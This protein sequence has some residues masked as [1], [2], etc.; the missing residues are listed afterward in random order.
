MTVLEKDYHL[1]MQI[2]WLNLQE[3]MEI[4]RFIIWMPT[5]WVCSRRQIS[6]KDFLEKD[7]R[8]LII[9]MELRLSFNWLIMKK[10]CKKWELVKLYWWLKRFAW[11]GETLEFKKMIQQPSEIREGW[12]MTKRIEDGEVRLYVSDGSNKIFVIDPEEFTV[13]KRLNVSIILLV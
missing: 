10:K 5:I 8:S 2:L 11:D 6:R 13:V 4:H 1:K 12:G 7:V 9:K 3:V